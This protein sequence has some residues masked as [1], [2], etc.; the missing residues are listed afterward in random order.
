VVAEEELLKADIKG[1]T[2]EAEL[3]ILD[4][5]AVLCRDLYAFYPMLIRYVDNNRSRWLKR[6]DAQSNE[7]FT[8]V[9]EI[10]ILWCK[11]HNFKREEQNFVVQNEINNLSFLTGESKT[12]MSKKDTDDEVKDHL[13]ENLHLQDKSDDLAVQWQMNLYKDVVVGSE[14]PTDPEQ[15]VDRIQSISAAVFHLEQVEQ[16]L[17][18]KKCVFQKLLSKQRKRAVVACFRMAPLYN[19]PRHRSINL[20]VLGYVRLWIETEEYSFEE[21]L[22]QDLAS[23]AEDEEEEGEEEK[24]KTFEEKEMEKQKILYQQA[25]LHARGAAEMVLQMISASKGRLGPMVTCTLKLGISILNGGNVLVQQKMLDYLKEKRDA[26]FFKSLS[27][28]MQSCSVLDLNAFERQ[29]K[30]EGLG[31]VTDEGSSKFSQ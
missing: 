14:E 5:F 18:M 22:V 6:P 16:P 12:K 15:T 2:Q 27:G 29:N 26:G 19:L 23:C 10:F 28:L 3:L 13:R 8:M 25:R 21:R 31:M 9:A 11:S 17:R 20:F 24:E 4:E 7:L 1:D 30:A